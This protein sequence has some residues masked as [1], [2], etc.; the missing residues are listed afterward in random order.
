[1][2]QVE[3]T[4]G[5]GK[6]PVSAHPAFP[7]IVALWFAALLGLGSLIL[8]VQ[9]IE[10]LVTATGIASL[11]PAAAPPLGFTARAAIALVATIFGALLGVVAARR[12]AAPAAAKASRKSRKGASSRVLNAAEDI[13]DEGIEPELDDMMESEEPRTSR[14]RALAL[15]ED[16]GPSELL[17]VAPLPSAEDVDHEDGDEI[18]MLELGEE[19]E[20]SGEFD[21]DVE[22]EEYLAEDEVEEEPRQEFVAADAP[23]EIAETVA[24]D[25]PVAG[26]PLAFSP[27]S[28]A[29]QP[30]VSF[31]E[32]GPRSFDH[33]EASEEEAEEYP[34]LA[35]ATLEEAETLPDA[36]EKQ[37][38][39]PSALS[40][41]EEQPTQTPSQDS[42]MD[43]TQ[44]SPATTED[45]NEVG[46]VQLVQKLGDTLEK[47]R[48]WSAQRA[49]EQEAAKAAQPEPVE[50]EAVEEE[51][52]EDEPADAAPAFAQDFEAARP[53]DAAEAM[54]AYFGKSDNV[55][56]EDAEPAA[57]EAQD[58]D[59]A[60][61][62]ESMKLRQ[63]DL[64]EDEEED[65]IA[66]LAASF[67]LPLTRSEPQEAPAPS[68]RPSF[69]IAPAPSPMVEEETSEA[70]VAEAEVVE[71]EVHRDADYGSLSR[72]ENP[73]KREA[74]EF[75]RV[76][77][78]EPE[79]DAAQPAVVFPNQAA[80]RAA[81]DFGEPQE[82]PAASAP[83]AFDPPS[84]PPAK[85]ASND[86]NERAL[87]EALLNLQRMSK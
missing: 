36:A 45:E 52:A 85:S 40:E 39:I 83:R 50:L 23:V 54:A 82:A 35:D 25:A 14:R 34:S 6:P 47:H 43:F 71:E 65:E 44:A 32:D 59:H 73:F 63:F 38:F 15:E 42:P 49:A 30:Q 28:M 86:D 55:A 81:P 4:R 80:R 21:P 64:G 10:R 62:A 33:P 41:E 37:M 75:V 48:E 46:L 51:V 87:R 8:P 13:A 3:E 70:E 19:V 18:D 57:V 79:A 16:A 17:N 74:A 72:L 11:I 84:D 78:P 68:P 1:M 31:T 56:A 77:E 7:A 29:R 20:F 61:F 27:P 67:S 58:D 2:E 5:G 24:E 26:E 69:D 66:D 60:S 9:L 12:V 22:P 53:D 76:E